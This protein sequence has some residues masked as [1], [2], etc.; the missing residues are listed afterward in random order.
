MLLFTLNMASVMFCVACPAANTKE[1]VVTRCNQHAEAELGREPRGG[2]D[3]VDRARGS[4]DCDLGAVGLVQGAGWEGLQQLQHSA[5][6]GA[7]FR[8]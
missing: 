2:E 6:G 7:N 3:A 5:G 8:P 1:S 4:H